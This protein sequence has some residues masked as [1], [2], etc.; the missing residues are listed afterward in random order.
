MLCTIYSKTIRSNKVKTSILDLE[1]LLARFH[2]DEKRKGTVEALRAEGPTLPP[3][4]HSR[5]SQRLP[6]ICPGLL[7]RKRRN[8]ETVTTYNGVVLLEV[9]GLADSMEIEG[10]KR[11]A[12]GWPTT[13][14]AFMG[15]S[16]RTVKILVSGTLDDG[17]LPRE[18]DAI[19]RF[20][21]RLY[22]MSAQ[23]YASVIGRPLRAKQPKPDDTFRW[24]YDPSPYLNLKAAPLRILRSDILRSIGLSVHAKEAMEYD[25]DSLQPSLAAEAFYRRRFALAVNTAKE[26]LT[27]KASAKSSITSKALLEGVALEALRLN[28]P[29]EEAVRQSIYNPC[30]RGVGVENVRTIVESVFLENASQAG[31]NRHHAAQELI[32][33]LQEF[34]KQRYDLRFNEL[35]NGVEWRR[36]HSA[37]F[38]FSPLDARVMNTMVQEAHESGLGITDRDLRRYLGS[39]RV[40]E[41]N[42][43]SAFLHRV[44]GCWDGHTDYIGVLADRVPNSNPLWRD[45]F[46]TWFLAMV[47]QWIGKEPTSANSL[48]PLLV[49]RPGCGKSS[50]GRMLL[51]P[52]LQ[53][54]GFRE[55]LDLSA[56]NSGERLLS[57]ALLVG[58]ES[59]DT[60]KEKKLQTFLEVFLPKTQVIGQRPYTHTLQRLPRYAS[61]IATANHTTVMTSELAARRFVVAEVGY[62][63]SVD[64][65]KPIDYEKTYAQAVE[66]L[67]AGIHDYRLSPDMQAALED[68]NS[69]YANAR[70]EVLRFFDTF[71]LKTIADDCTR[72]MKLSDIAD[73]VRRQTGYS[74]SDKSFNYL[75]RWLTGEAK[76]QRVKKTVSNG[77]PVYL[78]RARN[79]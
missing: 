53:E 32:F 51:P 67:R 69:R 45:V 61:F 63:Q 24:T 39:T 1:E 12:A 78:L 58:L 18:S 27:A 71:E 4:L 57:E 55:S 43:A 47:A 23:A 52:E 15:S 8:G 77:S 31:H 56:R 65:K 64:L 34:L 16:G 33:S 46:H 62:S 28:I 11:R 59:F 29:Q 13:L 48:V 6:L 44:E 79:K 9:C 75:G 40:R 10:V 22:E 2:N 19:D 73:A 25:Q 35:T 30:F 42:A 50:F 74:Y 60:V 14:A 70:T 17:T 38:D 37:S 21:S 41:Y 20:H 26:Q 68:Y 5:Y 49:G 3:S 36:N 66:E 54:V 72:R 7:L 76:A